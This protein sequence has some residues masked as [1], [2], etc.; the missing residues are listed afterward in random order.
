MR[1][2]TADEQRFEEEPLEKK[3]TEAKAFNEIRRL[4]AENQWLEAE[5]Q[6]LRNQFQSSR[7][8]PPLK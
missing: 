8:N 7:G 1:T 6:R 5:N 2:N 3:G 4:E